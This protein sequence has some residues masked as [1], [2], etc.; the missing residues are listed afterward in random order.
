[1][2][3]MNGLVPL[4]T[5]LCCELIFSG[6]MMHSP[7][8][9]KLL[10]GKPSILISNGAINQLEMRKNR[11]TLDELAEELRTQGITDISKVKYAILE[12]DGRVN[13]LLYPSE[14]PVTAGQLNI[15]VPDP[16]Y[17]A[18]LISDG[19]ISHENLRV[20]DKS[21]AWLMKELKK[22]NAKSPKEV[23]LLSLN[24]RGEIYYAAKEN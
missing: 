10:T 11:F 20:M 12:T 19:K 17:T 21:E 9:K 4:A 3:L 23:Y 14:Q 16:G 5:L 6:I 24:H 18:I 8:A 22:R 15:Q 2:P 1:M 7:T 13:T